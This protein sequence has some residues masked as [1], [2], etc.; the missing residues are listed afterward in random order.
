MS[1]LR[2]ILRQIPQ[3]A[4][5]HP[6]GN[7]WTHTRAVRYALDPALKLLKDFQFDE[8]DRKLLRLAAWCHDLGKAQAT[9][10]HDNRWIAPG[11]EKPK[12]LNAVL[13]QLG[14]PW[15]QFWRSGSIENRKAFLH[16]CIR[17]MAISDSRGIDRRI[18]R[19]MKSSDPHRSH[20]AKL[21]IV[22]M[23]MDRLGTTRASRRADAQIVVDAAFAP[24]AVGGG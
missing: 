10:L 4:E 5:F 14:R 6:E 17:H 13:R 16:L 3:D 18:L 19:A 9:I 8:T 11:H 15:E 21:T 23:V 7:V 12:H 20:R 24:F 1:K 22:L 2:D